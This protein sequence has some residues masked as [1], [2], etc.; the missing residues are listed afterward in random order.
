MMTLDE[1]MNRFRLASRELF[2]QFFHVPKATSEA[3]GPPPDASSAEGAEAWDMETRFSH[4]EEMLFE[5]MVCE[6]GQLSHVEYGK[7]H[8]EIVVELSSPFC[9][10]M[11]NRELNSGYWDFPI[12]EVTDDAYL[13]FLKFFDWDML[14][15]RDNRYVLVQVGEWPSHPEAVGKQAL[16]ESQY[17]HFVRATSIASPTG[18]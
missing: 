8:K 17:V 2:N 9:P 12:R 4:V 1:M 5:K 3:S 14:G 15:Y 7:L 13:L 11:L 16:I 10:I 6:P 18:N